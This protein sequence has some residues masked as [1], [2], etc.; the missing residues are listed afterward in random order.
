MGVLATDNFD[1]SNGASLGANWTAS[2]G[3]WSIASNLAVPTSTA[4]DATAF[5]NAVTWPNNQYSQA[6]LSGIGGNVNDGTGPGLCVRKNSSTAARYRF[7][8]HHAATQ[9]TELSVFN[10]SYALVWNRTQAWTNAD[11]LYL[12]IQGTTLIAKVNGAAIG[13]STTNSA[14]SSGNAGVDYSSTLNTPS[15]NDWEGGDFA[16]ATKAPPP[17]RRPYRFFTR[18][19]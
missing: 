7:V 3:G 2:G 11:T 12:E 4:S 5:Y 18:S 9:N 15:D 10:T 13:T 1:R 16:A 14:I 6:K 19:Y 8:A 17:F